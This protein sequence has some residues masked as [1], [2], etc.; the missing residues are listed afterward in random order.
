LNET[1]SRRLNGNI[2]LRGANENKGRG[3]SGV[4]RDGERGADDEQCFLSFVLFAHICMRKAKKEEKKKKDSAAGAGST[5]W[6]V[7]WRGAPEAVEDG[8][9]PSKE[10][11]RTGIRVIK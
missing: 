6:A 4:T 3:Q 1:E 11:C 7:E 2:S 8:E 10:G 9:T 5:C